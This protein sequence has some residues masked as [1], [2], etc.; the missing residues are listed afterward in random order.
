[1][2]KALRWKL[3]LLYLFAALALVAIG[4]FGTYLLID[5]Y[6]QQT[7]DLALQYK[8][9]LEF[10]ILGLPVPKALEEAE[11]LWLQNNQNI[12]S[13]GPI[14]DPFTKSDD[15]HEHDD[16]DDDDKKIVR[17]DYVYNADLA[18]IFVILLDENGYLITVPG[19]PVP[20]MVDSAD[21]LLTVQETG[22]DMRTIDV[23]GQGRVRLLSYRTGANVPAILQVGRLL[24]DQDRVLEQY[25]TY[26]GF[27]GGLLSILLSFISWLL[28]GRS[29]G[30][31]QKAF[32]QQQTFV[33]NASHELRTPLTFIRA[34]AD[35]RLRLKPPA[36]EAEHLE[37]ILNECDYM[38]RLVDD[39]LLLTRLDAN[40]LQL[41]LDLLSLPELF[42]EI[43]TRVKRRAETEGIT[44]ISGGYDG[45]IYVDHTRIRQVLLILLDNALRFTPTGGKIELTAEKSGKSILIK[46]SDTGKGVDPKHLPHLFDRFYQVGTPENAENRSNGLGLSIARTLIEAHHGTIKVESK[47]GQGAHFTIAL[48]DPKG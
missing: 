48:P 24:N 8:M 43:L 37:N 36:E 25:L 33:S 40:R 21:A 9:A 44:L 2:L 11:T 15:D 7:T 20:P 30:P 35:Y 42:A 45:D 41:D 22:Y 27:F 12:V 14:S 47:L 3:T 5:H 6:F 16:D 13:P 10:R 28:A 1:M 39:L 29:L 23:A 19:V 34:T 17:D 46:V 26:L 31:A 32:D 4:G 18:A 38:D